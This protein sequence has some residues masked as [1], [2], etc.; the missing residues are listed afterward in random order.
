MRSLFLLS[1]LV[2]S[3]LGAPA[4]SYS[5]GGGGAHVL[6][7]KRS[8]EVHYDAWVKRE[9]ADPASKVPVRIALK[10]RNLE[11]AMDLVLEV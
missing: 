6:H 11:R 8:D 3:A 2:A 1:G 9:P 7:Q 10:Q 4:T 5:G